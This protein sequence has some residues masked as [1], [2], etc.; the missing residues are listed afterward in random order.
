M[1]K[2][3]SSLGLVV[4]AEL[5]VRL[6]LVCESTPQKAVERVWKWLDDLAVAG[7]I[8]A[9]L[10]PGAR[11]KHLC[12][13]NPDAVAKALAGLAEASGVPAEAEVKEGPPPESEP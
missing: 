10:V 12:L 2:T 7:K 13:Y 11:G 1:T 6:E 8:P 9:L 4:A 3:T 5:A